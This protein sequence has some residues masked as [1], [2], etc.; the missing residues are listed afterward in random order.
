MGII[1]NDNIK[2]NAGKP[3]ESKYL[4]T[5]NTVYLSISEVTG[6]TGVPISERYLGLTVNINNTEYWFKTGVTNTDLIE[7]KYDSTIPIEDF[8]TG[9]TNI[10]FFSGYTGVQTL[11]LSTLNQAPLTNYLDYDGDYVSQYNWFYRGDDGIIHV[12]IP[13]DGIAKR[14]YVKISP[15]PI[16][17]WIWNEYTGGTNLVG[18]ILIDGNINNMIGI[19]QAGIEY[20]TGASK[21][22]VQ[23]AWT[24]PTSNGSSVA[25]STVNGSLTTGDTLTIGGPVFNYKDDNE[26]YLRTIKTNSPTIIDVTYDEAFVYISGT[27]SVLNRLSGATNG[28]TAMDN[29]V[30]LGGVLTGA[31]IISIPNTTS[32]TFNDTRTPSVGVQYDGDYSATFSARSIVDAGY[33]TG[34]TYSGPL[35]KSVCL[36]TTSN[37][38]AVSTDYYIGVTG[39]TWVTLPISPSC[40]M[41]LIIADISSL[42]SVAC[43]ILISGNIYGYPTAEI[44]TCYGSLSLIYNGVKWGV[45]AFP[46][47]IA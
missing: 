25:I 45:F 5:G 41:S 47:A 38:Q 11:S 31:T 33:V 35:I 13:N 29:I 24:T 44:D 8:I 2:I 22:Y 34:I 3:S 19:S 36:P 7:K 10:G 12:G 32:L 4:S 46:P 21:V 17:S 23:T 27:T 15:S 1:L 14:G 26:F 20:Y 30:S 37:Y 42:A 18:W 16:K 9:A 43:P 6:T 39:G 40:G 28:L